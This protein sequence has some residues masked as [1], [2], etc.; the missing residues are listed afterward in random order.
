MEL[1]FEGKPAK[2]F[3]FSLVFGAGWRNEPPHL[4]NSLSR[5]LEELTKTVKEKVPEYFEV[6]RHIDAEFS[7][8]RIWGTS[9]DVEVLLDAVQSVLL[10][11]HQTLLELGGGVLFGV[12]AGAIKSEVL[13]EMEK[14]KVPKS[15]KNPKLYIKPRNFFKTFD[16][17]RIEELFL[18]SLLKESSQEIYL[19]LSPFGDRIHYGKNFQLPSLHSIP[20][21]RKKF[22]ALI[23]RKV[24]TTC[25]TVDLLVKLNIFRKERVL[26]RELFEKIQD[27]DLLKKLD[28]IEKMF[29]RV[30]S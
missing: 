12:A 14:M 5:M 1:I 24:E 13:K 21:N 30:L 10:L 29:R 11:P 25:G 8:L 9:D 23:A 26:I 28:V 2:S 3:C 15:P 22:V 19:E 4:K 17:S 6:S 18:Y 20:E 7:E 16:L 27:M